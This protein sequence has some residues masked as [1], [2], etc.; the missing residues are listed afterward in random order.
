MKGRK[1]GIY[2]IA[3]VA[4]SILGYSY[5]TKK[6]VFNKSFRLYAYV[7]KSTGITT[8]STVQINGFNRF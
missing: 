5:I 1:I 2:V 8:K 4:L 3:V 6:G 7:D